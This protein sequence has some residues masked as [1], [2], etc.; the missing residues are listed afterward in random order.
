MLAAILTIVLGVVIIMNPFTAVEAAWSA[1][2]YM[3]IFT[4]VF[5]LFVFIFSFFL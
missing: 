5:D 4:G 2:G 3:L 1:T